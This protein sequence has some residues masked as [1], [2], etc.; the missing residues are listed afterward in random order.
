MIK[1]FL[2]QNGIGKGKAGDISGRINEPIE[3]V[4]RILPNEGITGTKERQN[5][6][7]R[8]CGFSKSSYDGSVK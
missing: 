3:G 6:V 8:L 4:G 7:K 5:F 2:K 1:E